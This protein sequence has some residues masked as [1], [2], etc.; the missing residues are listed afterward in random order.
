[1]ALKDFKGGEGQSMDLL[2]IIAKSLR[3]TSG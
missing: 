3:A 2:R 1:M